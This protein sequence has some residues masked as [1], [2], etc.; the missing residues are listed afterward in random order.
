MTYPVWPYEAW[1]PEFDSL[2]TVFV[3]NLICL[4][5]FKGGL[6]CWSWGLGV[7]V[8][9]IVIYYI[10]WVTLRWRFCISIF[11]LFL[12]KKKQRT[13]WPNSVKI[14]NRISDKKKWNPVSGQPKKIQFK[15]F[16]RA[17][18]TTVSAGTAGSST[19]AASVLSATGIY[20]LHTA[21][22]ESREK[23]RNAR[24]PLFGPMS[25]NGSKN[26]DWAMAYG[27]ICNLQFFFNFE[28]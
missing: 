2:A 15:G 5:Y 9:G 28:H 16:T 17:S 27:L 10:K 1:S 18:G 19:L 23:G 20:T 11:R 12:Y 4:T 26:F 7:L 8:L 3:I 21:Q 24:W 13:I 22:I 25:S 6:L 14:R